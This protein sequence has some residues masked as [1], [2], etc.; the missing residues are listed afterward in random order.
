VEASEFHLLS[1]FLSG[2]SVAGILA[3][4]ANIISISFSP[5]VYWEAFAFFMSAALVMSFSWA[6]YGYIFGCCDYSISEYDLIDANSNE[7]SE[8]GRVRLLLI[9]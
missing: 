6:A 9:C 5:N 4:V 1:P 7:V 8:E 2:Q 3:A